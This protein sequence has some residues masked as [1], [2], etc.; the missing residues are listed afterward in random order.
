[1]T[2][3]SHEIWMGVGMGYDSKK[4]WGELYSGDSPIAYPAEGVIR[5]FKGTF[6][7]LTM[8]RDHANLSILD[9][10]CGAIGRCQSKTALSRNGY[11][12]GL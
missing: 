7:A 2:A 1:M 12:E 6:P 3:Q 4:A 11:A 9:M 10:G 8:P 5:I